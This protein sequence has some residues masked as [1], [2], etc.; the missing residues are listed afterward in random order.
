[1]V[2]EVNRSLQKKRGST[3]VYY[4]LHG[5]FPDVEILSTRHY[6]NVM[7]GVPEDSLFGHPETTAC[8]RAVMQRIDGAEADNKIDRSGK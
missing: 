2:G 8:Q 1:M 4:C 7:E 3:P 6:V 5:N